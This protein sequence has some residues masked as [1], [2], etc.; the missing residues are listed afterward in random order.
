MKLGNSVFSILFLC[1]ILTMLAFAGC[2]AGSALTAPEPVSEK[3]AARTEAAVNRALD[4][5]HAAI[6]LYGAVQRCLGKRYVDDAGGTPVAR[7]SN[8]QLTFASITQFT[9]PS[10]N[11]ARTA[12]FAGRLRELE[13]PFLAVVAPTKLSFPQVEM[14]SGVPDYG[15]EIADAFLAALE[16]R[17]DSFD[18]RPGFVRDGGAERFFFQTDHHWTPEGALYACGLLMDELHGRFGF[19]ALEEALSPD[20]Y[21]VEVYEDFF[22]GSQGKRVG[23]YYAGLDDFS[24]FSPKFETAFTCEIPERSLV[25]TGTFN[26]ALC[27]EERLEAGDPFQTN[28][29]SYYSG[30]DWAE[31]IMT[32]L[33]NPDGPRIVLIRESFSCALAPFLALQCSQLVTIDLRYYSGDLPAE[34][35]ALRPDLVLMLYSASSTRLPELFQFA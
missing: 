23:V 21:D 17:A 18:L 10:E 22:L 11:A 33:H 34:V 24:V 31:S 30:G 9:D 2:A 27:F 12:E 32:N 35:D 29:Y 14:P 15:N 3:P 5:N 16:G 20:C 13:I 26:E 28:P 19:E 25:R 8:G 1:L 4:Q 7:L 6:N